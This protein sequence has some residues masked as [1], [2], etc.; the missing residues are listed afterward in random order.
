MPTKYR[1]K[2]YPKHSWKYN[3]GD[4]LS[5]RPGSRALYIPANLRTHSSFSIITQALT[6]AD[7]F[8]PL[9]ES[10]EAYDHYESAFNIL[11]KK[12]ND[13]QT[14][15]KFILFLYL[16]AFPDDYRD[17]WLYFMDIFHY[18]DFLSPEF[19]ERRK[20]AAQATFTYRYDN[21]TTFQFVLLRNGARSL[22]S[23][24]LISIHEYPA[25]PLPDNQC[26]PLDRR[27]RRKLNDYYW[28]NSLSLEEDSEDEPNPVV[29][30]NTHHQ[31]PAAS[32]PPQPFFT[33]TP[34]S[35]TQPIPAD[36]PF[37]PED[38]NHLHPLDNQPVPSS[39]DFIDLTMDE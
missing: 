18:G 30:P 23:N 29:T 11:A 4:I 7:F 17:Q 38:I 25:V 9:L 21:Y 19:I 12:L 32:P 36:T 15:Y 24:L 34:P 1:T 37:Q 3:H 39:E 20:K 13:V 6:L 8:K 10:Y 27:V 26:I 33:L 16:R 35:P 2:H 31:Y 5:V 28:D 14:H 22:S